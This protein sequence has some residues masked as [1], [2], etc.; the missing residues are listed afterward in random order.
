MN[1][2]VLPAHGHAPYLLGVRLLKNVA[3]EILLPDF[4]GATQQRILREEFPADADRIFLSPQ[5]GAL[6]KPLL[7]DQAF[8]PDVDSF[9]RSVRENFATTS[10]ALDTLCRD[11]IP[12]VSLHNQP[13]KF[14]RFDLAL[15]TGLPVLSPLRPVFFAFVGRMSAIY[16]LS[17]YQSADIRTLAE[18]WKLIEATFACMYVPR[19]NSLS[20]LDYDPS[21]ITFT[22]PFARPYPRDDTAIPHGATLVIASGTGLDVEKLLQLAAS[23]PADYVTFS[24]SPECVPFARVPS[25]VWGNGSLSAVLARSGFGSIWQAQVNQKPIGVV[26]PHPQDDPEV[27]HNAKAVEWSGI[28]AALDESVMPLVDG[29]ARFS[30]NLKAQMEIDLGMFGTMNGIEYASA[31]LARYLS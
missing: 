15:N 29:L 11:G 28:G 18:T 27:F 25:A 8:T 13:K 6:L 1:G 7:L 3:D 26:R 10:R 21:G 12:A 24:G 4:Y 22:P 16:E 19:L 30:E 2:L 9:S 17:P 23:H 14:S 20:Y 31:H 5:L